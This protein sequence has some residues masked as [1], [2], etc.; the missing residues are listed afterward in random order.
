MIT[1]LPRQFFLRP[2]SGVTTICSDPIDEAAERPVLGPYGMA[3]Y[4]ALLIRQDDAIVRSLFRSMSK[5]NCGKC[6]DCLPVQNC[7][8][9]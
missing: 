2:N 4:I 6:G 1:N 8:L 5:W 9:K 7:P 3:E